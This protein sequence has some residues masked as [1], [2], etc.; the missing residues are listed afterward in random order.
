MAKSPK[1]NKNL[2]CDQ[3][4]NRNSIGISKGRPNEKILLSIYAPILKAEDIYF[5]YKVHYFNLR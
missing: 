3:N 5:C 1:I 4:Y 2:F